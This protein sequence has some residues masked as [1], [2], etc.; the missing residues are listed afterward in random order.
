MTT[1]LDQRGLSS[2]KN[3]RMSN[4]Q[5]QDNLA[6][7]FASVPVATAQQGAHKFLQPGDGYYDGD[8]INSASH[9]DATKFSNSL[10]QINN[11]SGERFV[12]ADVDTGESADANTGDWTPPS[13]P[14][15][16]RL[17]VSEEQGFSK[18][19]CYGK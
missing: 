8:G 16:D 14:Y 3:G 15:R 6:K 18:T 9:V 11:E 10:N 5:F 7:E 2:W 1:R 19:C 17:S 4:T 13:V 12:N